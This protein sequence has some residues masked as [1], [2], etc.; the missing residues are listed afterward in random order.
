M[1]VKAYTNKNL[2]EVID[3]LRQDK[4]NLN[5]DY[6]TKSL[7]PPYILDRNLTEMSEAISVASVAP[8]NT[9]NTK[10]DRDIVILNETDKNVVYIGDES[11][12][13]FHISFDKVDE[14]DVC[15]ITYTIKYESNFKI[16]LTDSLVFS[17]F[18]SSLDTYT[19][20]LSDV[21]G[22][23]L[24]N[25]YLPYNNFNKLDNKLEISVNYKDYI[26]NYKEYQYITLV[27]FVRK[28]SKTN[29]RLLGGANYLDSANTFTTSN[30]EKIVNLADYSI[31]N[32]IE[33]KFGYILYLDKNNS[34]VFSDQIERSEKISSENRGSV[35]DS[36]IQVIEQVQDKLFSDKLLFNSTEEVESID[37]IDVDSKAILYTIT[38][39]KSF[40]SHF[41]DDLGLFYLYNNK[42]F[43]LTYF[44]LKE[45]D[46]VE[47]RINTKG[48]VKVLNTYT[49]TSNLSSAFEGCKISPLYYSSVFE[50][51]NLNFYMEYS[52]KKTITP[53]QNIIRLSTVN[54]K[55]IVVGICNDFNTIESKEEILFDNQESLREKVEKIKESLSKIKCNSVFNFSNLEL[56]F[57]LDNLES[58]SIYFY[59]DEEYDIYNLEGCL[60]NYKSTLFFYGTEE[61]ET[62]EIQDNSYL[63]VPEE[64]SV[65]FYLNSY[66]T[67]TSVFN[68]EELTELSSENLI[69]EFYNS[70]L[71]FYLK[72]Y[73]N[74]DANIFENISQKDI[75]ANV[76]FERKSD[77][78]IGYNSDQK[79]TITVKQDH[80]TKILNVP[81]N[82]SLEDKSYCVSL[83]SKPVISP[84]PS[85]CKLQ[86]ENKDQKFVLL[87]NNNLIEN[88]VEIDLKEKES[89]SN[90]YSQLNYSD[91]FV[92][93]TGNI[94]NLVIKSKMQV[95]K[96][97][98]ESEFTFYTCSFCSDDTIMLSKDGEQ[99]E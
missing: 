7:T 51:S 75:V 67:N 63:V 87:L 15:K 57:N 98:I 64:E 53:K 45:E 77:I 40:S 73:S 18:N 11:R 48:K 76:G 59:M 44:D 58:N 26:E 9:L 4:N 30:K 69:N 47:V 17:S 42:T 66:K 89:D 81:Y 31:N 16:D 62:E 70:N 34:L 35:G 1:S 55:K 78:K 43:Y 28:H 41:I 37:L 82:F 90:F 83:L 96:I 23:L 86:L 61:T 39:S 60:T 93:I 80:V 19:Y 25:V 5:P 50:N 21:T 6:T 20:P 38:L 95:L 85:L 49:D 88:K 12:A 3:K 32:N 2:T 33:D 52:K 13:L 14:G 94:D 24:Q 8:L 68:E 56:T 92:E 71:P 91:D 79:Y 10:F 84:Y 54:F 22:Y 65:N 29:L 46:A 99:Y 72:L 27:K 97:T 74:D 36:S